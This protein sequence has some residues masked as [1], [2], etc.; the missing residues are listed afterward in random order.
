MPALNRHTL[1]K[2][3]FRKKEKNK[4]G[5]LCRTLHLWGVHTPERV[6][7]AL[8]ASSVVPCFKAHSLR[9]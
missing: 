7:Y 3:S 9:T 1:T 2:Q 8:D 6:N 5:Y 4:G